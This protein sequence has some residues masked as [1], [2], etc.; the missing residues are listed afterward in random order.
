MLL[1][2]I[3]R[4]IDASLIRRFQGAA[5]TSSNKSSYAALAKGQ[6]STVDISTALRLGAQTYAASLKG[7]NSAGAMVQL[8]KSTLAKLSDLTEKLMERALK[9]AT[10]KIGLEGRMRLDSDFR[11]LGREF[12]NVVANAKVGEREYLSVNGLKEIFTTAGLS[13]EDSETINELFQ[14]FTTPEKDDT[15]ASDKTRA[16]TPPQIPASAFIIDPGGPP[17]WLLRQVS[18][19]NSN[20]AAVNQTGAVA[21]SSTVYKTADPS[22]GKYSLQ[23]AN[24]DGSSAEFSSPTDFTLMEVQPNTGYSVIQSAAD[25]LPGQNTLQLNQ[26]F[27]IDDTGAPIHQITNISDPDRDEYY[28]VASTPDG[29]AFAIASASPNQDGQSAVYQEVVGA[30]GAAPGGTI[31]QMLRAPSLRTFDHVDISSDGSFMA[32]DRQFGA[33]KMVNVADTSSGGTIDTYLDAYRV[34]DHGFTADGRLLCAVDSDYDQIAD[35]VYQYQKDAQT[36]GEPIISGVRIEKF[37]TL[38]DADTG[39][40]YFAYTSAGAEDRSTVHVLATDGTEIAAYAP[41]N[42]TDT[43]D[44]ISLAVNSFGLVDIGLTGSLNS[45]AGSSTKEVYRLTG[46]PQLPKRLAKALKSFAELFDSQPKLTNRVN[47]YVIANDLKALHEQIQ[48]NV[49]A[50]DKAIETLQANVD[51]A[52][53]TGLAMLDLSSTIKSDAQAEDV[54]RQL[55]LAV[56]Q[57]ARRALAQAENLNSIAAAALLLDENGLSAKQSN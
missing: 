13:A 26:L 33:Y 30:Y 46:V 48:K 3:T 18:T 47:A 9:A 1:T 25:L 39:Q 17:Q 29:Q 27:L 5:T 31:N 19:T 24:T 21:G 28:S 11:K 15:L 55:A 35:S 44:N 51:L 4:I 20:P 2:A 10:T 8:S 45:A 42:P 50:L 37:A 41:P 23:I 12:R 32:Y 49:K 34:V 38:A 6:G 14:E 54:A 40:S 16:D 57:N 53:G 43:I 22:A 7:L 36:L 52:R 56:R